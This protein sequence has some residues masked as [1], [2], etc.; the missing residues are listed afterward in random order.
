VCQRTSPA[1]RRAVPRSLDTQGTVC[2]CIACYALWHMKIL[3]NW[4][5]FCLRCVSAIDTP[6][7]LP[8]RSHHTAQN[9]T[10]HRT[11]LSATRLHGVLAGI[12]EGGSN[13]ELTHLFVI[14]HSAMLLR[15]APVCA[16]GSTAGLSVK[17]FVSPYDQILCDLRPKCNNLRALHTEHLS[18]EEVP[19]REA[20][21]GPDKRK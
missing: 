3:H 18:Y 6:S 21:L 15:Y 11:A 7:F 13:R 12:C 8:L 19:S 1:L 16:V 17:A 9:Y 20:L 5:A 14:S 4:S 2:G 10:V